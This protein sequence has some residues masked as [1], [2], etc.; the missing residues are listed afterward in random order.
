VAAL[1]VVTTV[2]TVAG[3]FA[4][5][6]SGDDSLCCFFAGTG[7]IVTAVAMLTDVLAYDGD[8]ADSV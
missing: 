4:Y 7:S 6:G 5:Y 3:V 8:G 2:A 1:A